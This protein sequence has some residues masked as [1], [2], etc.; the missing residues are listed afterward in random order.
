MGAYI[1][2]YGSD[3][4]ERKRERESVCVGWYIGCNIHTHEREIRVREINMG[5]RY[6]YEGETN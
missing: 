3:T 5:Q 1:Y 2:M 6:M 4:F